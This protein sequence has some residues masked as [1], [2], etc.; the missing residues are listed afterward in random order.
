MPGNLGASPNLATFGHPA[1]TSRPD[2]RRASR[3][4]LEIHAIPIDL[5]ER[6]PGTG[7]RPRARAA[8]QRANHGESRP[9]GRDRHQARELEVPSPPRLSRSGAA[10]GRRS[11]GLLGQLDSNQHLQPATLLPARRFS[12]ERSTESS[13]STTS[14]TRRPSLVALQ[15]TDQAKRRRGPTA[16]DWGA[17]TR[18]RRRLNGRGGGPTSTP[19]GLGDRNQGHPPGVGRT[20]RGGGDPPAGATIRPPPRPAPPLPP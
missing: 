13:D 5:S 15:V 3:S 18:R 19:D 14:K 9:G 10:G 6:P 16:G 12:P 20:G 7:R 8:A 4:R 17:S 2:D 1:E 11:R